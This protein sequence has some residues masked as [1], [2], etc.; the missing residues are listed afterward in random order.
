MHFCHPC[1]HTL[2]HA[3][4]EVMRVEP[5]AYSTQFTMER[6]I[7]DL[8]QEIRQPSN[9]FTNLAWHA[10]R[11]SRLGSE[12]QCSS[13]KSAMDLENS[14]IMSWLR[15][16]YSTQVP[17]PAAGVL[18]QAVNCQKLGNGAEFVSRMVR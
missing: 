15:E 17:E 9:P 11:I 13:T 14:Y 6:T 18:L 16:R 7:G 4:P 8:G 5:G 12:G 3:C 2:L 10:L 1:I